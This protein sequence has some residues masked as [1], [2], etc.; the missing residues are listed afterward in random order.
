M[1]VKGSVTQNS[2]LLKGKNIKEDECKEKR[3]QVKIL[4]TPTK[5][6]LT[7]KT[8]MGPIYMHNK[9]DGEFNH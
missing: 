3:Q 8:S 5:D 4:S 1:T 7:V 2:D 9:L 6:T